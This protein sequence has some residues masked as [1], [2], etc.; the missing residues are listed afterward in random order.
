MDLPT[1][2]CQWVAPQSKIL[3]SKAM[4]WWLIVVSC[5]VGC[6]RSKPSTQDKPVNIQSNDA[7]RSTDEVSLSR[8]WC[9][10]GASYAS[11]LNAFIA[12]GNQEGW[13][14]VS[15]KDEPKDTRQPLAEAVLDV[16]RRANATG[17]IDGLRDRFPPAHAPFM[18]LLEEN[19]QGLPV[20]LLLDD[21][22]IV[23]RIG[24]PYEAGK[25]VMIDGLR[26]EPLAPDIITVGR[27]PQRTHF[28]VANSDGVT[29]HRGWDGPVTAVLKWPTGLEGI[30]AGFAVVPLQGPPVVTQL[31]PFDWGDKVLLVSPSGIFV[32]T[33]DAARRVLPTEAQMREH[34]EWLKKEYPDDE[35]AYDL[36]MD[37][38]ALSPDG[39]LIAAGH[40]SSTHLVFDA[41]TLEVVGD[42]G[43]LSEYP[44]YAVFSDDG[45]VIAFNSCHF[46]S[47]ATIGIATDL[48]PGLK[49]EPYEQ[50]ERIVMLEDGARVYAAVCRDGEFIIGDAG[51]YL[52]A[53]DKTGTFR[54][55]HFIGSTISAIDVSRDGKQLVVA[56]YA[57]FLSVIDLDTG[58]SDSH[59]IGS[60]TNRER[61]RWIFWKNE[62]TPLVW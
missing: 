13:D 59:A 33:L 39:K 21:G 56:T 6:G 9:D 15:S 34:F 28:A 48:L 32:L 45:S 36:D 44:H 54:W 19:G 57:G 35:P 41:E 4:L 3:E 26:V 30:P 61:R 47:G 24:A 2:L 27:S 12:R 25:V 11:A 52:H 14:K 62:K 60:S 37:H 18:N 40:Q 31:I 53:F 29:V 16:V 20:V 55:N 58:S 22:R 5:L 50:D 23:A 1:K 43:N 46:Y 17:D 38:G 49:T 42:I 10:E 51:G 8:R 7:L